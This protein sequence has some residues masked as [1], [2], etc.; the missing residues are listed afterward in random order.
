MKWGATASNGNPLRIQ[1]VSSEAAK[2]KLYPAVWELN[3]VRVRS[4]PVPAIL[5]YDENWLGHIRRLFCA[6]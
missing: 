6:R 1:F 5:A 2:V 3:R 4:A